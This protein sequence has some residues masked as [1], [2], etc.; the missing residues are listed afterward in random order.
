MKQRDPVSSPPSPAAQLERL[1]VLTV[2]LDESTDPIF[3]ILED[4]TYRYVNRAFST[5]FGR[6]PEEVI[7][8]RIYDIFSIDEAEKRM[9]V[10]KRAFATG[11]TIVFDVRVP[12]PEGDRFYITSV[13]PIRDREGAVASVVCISK[14]ITERKRSELEQERLIRELQTALQQV[15]TLSGMLPICAH[16]KKIRDDRGYWNQIEAYICQH[17]DAEFTHGICPDCLRQHYAPEDIADPAGE[18]TSSKPSK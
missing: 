14:E 9:G 6:T 8:R 4:G 3:N 1:E 11:E 17:S 13:K 12:T 5:P 15:R 18:A 10:V 16:C 2:V 7:G